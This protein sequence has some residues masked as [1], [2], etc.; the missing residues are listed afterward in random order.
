VTITTEFDVVKDWA[1]VT[2]ASTPTHPDHY[3]QALW[4]ANGPSAYESKSSSQ[5]WALAAVPIAQARPM[6]PSNAVNLMLIFS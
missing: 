5:T 3:S 1:L 4:A 2:S 6:L